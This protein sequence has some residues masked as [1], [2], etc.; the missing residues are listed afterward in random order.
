MT[1]LPYIIG[2]YG[3][4][5][6]VVGWLAVDTWLRSRRARITMA[7]IDPRGMR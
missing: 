1:H 4:T 7:K 6:I 5:F 2:S 3:L